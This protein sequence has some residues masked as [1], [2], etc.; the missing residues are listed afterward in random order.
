ML[1]SRF[2][3]S[4]PLRPVEFSSTGLGPVRPPQPQPQVASLDPTPL[5]DFCFQHEKYGH[6]NEWLLLAWTVISRCPLPR[7]AKADS[8][9]SGTET[10][11]SSRGTRRHP[12]APAG[13]PRASFSRS[14]VEANSNPSMLPFCRRPATRRAWNSR[15]TKPSSRDSL[16]AYRANDGGIPESQG[17][18]EII[19]EAPPGALP[20]GSPPRPATPKRR[21]ARNA[22]FVTSRIRPP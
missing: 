11:L 2:R 16:P 5:D 3:L 15:I 21:E 9:A 19:Q 6:A 22:P 8:A 10:G 12:T 1:P 14:G 13:R 20:P 17:G 4:T 18:P 7:A